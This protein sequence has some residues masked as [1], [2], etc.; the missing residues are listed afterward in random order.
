MLAR[1]FVPLVVVF[2]LSACGGSA[3]PE[4]PP[5]RGVEGPGFRFAVPDGW[6]VGRRDDAVIARN[7]DAMVSVTTYRLL[8]PYDP[9]A[10][11]RVAA[12]LDA[13]VAKLARQAGGSVVER[14]TTEVAGRKSREYRY[15][16]RGF[17]SRLAFVFE[18]QKEWQL[19]CRARAED[20][21]PGGAC[22]LLLETFSVS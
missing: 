20:D 21:D 12:E 10:F 16:A 13:A 22:A 1:A 11:E 17:A 8:K 15:V 9:A 7:G 4:P 18:G 19:L 14:K 3:L 6:K 5:T 2:I